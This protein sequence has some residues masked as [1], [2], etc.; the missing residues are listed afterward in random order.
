MAVQ[1]LPKEKAT[2][3]G[4]R[5]CFYDKIKVNGLTKLYVYINYMTKA[6]SIKAERDFIVVLTKKF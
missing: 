4:R 3:D 2:K 6:K 5:W 1:Q